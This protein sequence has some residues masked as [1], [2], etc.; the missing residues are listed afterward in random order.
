MSAER[1]CLIAQGESPLPNR[2]QAAVGSWNPKFTFERLV[3]ASFQR[4]LDSLPVFGKKALKPR[5]GIL[6]QALADLP[7]E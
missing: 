7:L 2:F 5:V 6:L 1:S 4:D 3:V